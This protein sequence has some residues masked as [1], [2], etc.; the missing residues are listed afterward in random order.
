MNTASGTSYFKRLTFKRH[1]FVLETNGNLGALE[2]TTFISL[3]LFS[4][5]MSQGYRYFSR[6]SDDR[7]GLK[8]LVHSAHSFTS[9]YIIY[10]E[11]VTRWSRSEGNS[12]PLSVTVL[13]E[14]I[15]TFIVQNFFIHRIHR[16]SGKH[17]IALLC[18]TMAFL[19]FVAA[20]VISAESLIDVPKTPNGVFV[21]SIGWLIGAAL[22]VG[23]ATDLLIAGFMLYY[24]RKLFSPT[25]FRS[26]TLVLNRLIRGSFQTGLLTSMTSVTVIICVRFLSNMVWVGIYIILAKLYALSLLVSLNARPP[27]MHREDMGMAVSTDLE[28]TPPPISVSLQITQPNITSIE[29]NELAQKLLAS[30]PRSQLS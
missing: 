10:Y 17:I 15:I 14:S 24:L 22:A 5:S 30:G 16:L 18:F 28:F 20:V 3:I 21:H 26:T 11:T 2:V 1:E 4:V 13:L 9:C 6:S 12:Y 29:I 27:K 25:N 7:A 8:F 19:R 23:V